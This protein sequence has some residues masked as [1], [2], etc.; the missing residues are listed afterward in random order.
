MTGMQWDSDGTTT[1]LFSLLDRG[2]PMVGVSG[3]IHSKTR[4]LEVH[5]P[6]S[7]TPSGPSSRRNRP[8]PG[9]RRWGQQLVVCGGS[10]EVQPHGCLPHLG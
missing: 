3:D 5:K 4:S 2:F 9:R 8:G 7:L 1:L 6:L 10:S